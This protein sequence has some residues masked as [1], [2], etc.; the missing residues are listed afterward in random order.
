MIYVDTNVF[1]YAIEGHPKFGPSCKRILADIDGGALEAGCS[2]LVLAELIN[3]LKR[4]N[5]TEFHGQ[6]R[7]RIDKNLEAVMSLPI[8]WFEMSLAVIERASRY[9]FDVNGIDYIHVSTMELNDVSEAIS[10]DRDL[11]KVGVI[12]RIDTLQYVESKK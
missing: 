9:G 5:E 12:K 1:V 6:P 8:V 11:D 2:M 10:A 7:L 4:L 3:V